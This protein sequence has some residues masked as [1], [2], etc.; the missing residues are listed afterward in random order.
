MT[1]VIGQSNYIGFG[2]RHS[3]ENRFIS[4]EISESLRLIVLISRK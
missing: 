3:N 2:L 1:V 4:R